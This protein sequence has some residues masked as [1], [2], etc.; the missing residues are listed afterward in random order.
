MPWTESCVMQERMKFIMNVLEG[1][2][3]M[4][5]LCGYYGISRK[6]GYKWVDRY[7]QGGVRSLYDRSRA[8]IHHPDEIT[9]QVKDSILAVKERFPKWGARKIRARLERIRPG[10]ERY[11][12]A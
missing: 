10:W 3:S 9:P 6:T 1:T 7:R 5:E 2:Y 8:P 12:A 11:P 4:S